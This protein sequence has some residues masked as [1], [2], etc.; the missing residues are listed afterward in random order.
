MR[1]G[2][3]GVNV[4]EKELFSDLRKENDTVIR[5]EAEMFPV[6]SSSCCKICTIHL[7][8]HPR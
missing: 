6:K 3:A 1:D 2:A 4:D 5:C 7:V 8:S